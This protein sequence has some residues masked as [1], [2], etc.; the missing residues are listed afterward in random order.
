MQRREVKRVCPADWACTVKGVCPVDGVCTEK[1][2][3]NSRGP[4]SDMRIRIPGRLAEKG[5][6][7]PVL[8]RVEEDVTTGRG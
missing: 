8:G 5:G 1:G 4:F 3:V 2:G 7:D 6:T